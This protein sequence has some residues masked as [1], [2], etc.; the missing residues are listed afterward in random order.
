MNPLLRKLDSVH[1]V[2]IG[3]IGMEGLARYLGS[4]GIAVQGSDA[5]NSQTLK[6]LSEDGFKIWSF[7]DSSH[8]EN[9]DLVV[10]SAHAGWWDIF[11]SCDSKI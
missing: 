2:G 11:W 6:F 1:L 7:H 4:V 3:G 8:I 10:I 5:S 9:V